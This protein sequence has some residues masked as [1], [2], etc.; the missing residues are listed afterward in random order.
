MGMEHSEL[1]HAYSELGRLGYKQTVFEFDS[2]VPKDSSA[3]A[4]PHRATVLVTNTETGTQRRYDAAPGSDWQRTFA[5]DLS[6]G[7]FG[8]APK[9]VAA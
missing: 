7:E 6:R 3:D 1:E 2:T 9:G 5:E 8:P 4:K